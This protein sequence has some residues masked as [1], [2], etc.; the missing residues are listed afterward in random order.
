M[1]FY[2]IL[3]IFGITIISYSILKAKPENKK[4]FL[5]G[6]NLV[7]L[8]PGSFFLSKAILGRSAINSFSDFL[9]IALLTFGFLILCYGVIFV[10]VKTSG[11][12]SLKGSTRE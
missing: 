2:I 10:I 4:G 12:Y 7:T 8:V 11:R 6:F 3:I 5:Y 1:A 9:F